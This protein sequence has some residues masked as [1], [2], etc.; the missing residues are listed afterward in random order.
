MRIVPWSV[1]FFRCVLFVCVGVCLVKRAMVHGMLFSVFCVYL[2]WCVF[3]YM[4]IVAWSG[5][6]MRFVCVCGRVFG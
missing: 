2:C 1:F 6:P 5:F 4:C 3:G